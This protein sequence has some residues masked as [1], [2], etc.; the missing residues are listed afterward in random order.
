MSDFNYEQIKYLSESTLIFHEENDGQDF[1]NNEYNSI[2]SLIQN[3][4]S[5]N[6]KSNQN[7]SQKNTA[8]KSNNL[9]QEN[10][11]EN[12][13]NDEK[14]YN[15]I[16][17]INNNENENS[18]TVNNKSIVNT[19]NKI[20]IK[21]KNKK[22]K[23]PIFSINKKWKKR[24][25]ERKRNR[26]YEFYNIMKRIKK[27]LLESILRYVN[28]FIKG[29]KLLKIENIV[30]K[31]SDVE[32]NKAL[33]DT[34]LKDILSRDIYKK[35]KK[36]ELHHNK[37]IIEEIYE[38]RNQNII[39]ILNMKLKE[40][41]D[42]FK[43]NPTLKLFYDNLIYEMKKERSDNYVGTFDYYFDNYSEICQRRRNRKKKED[44]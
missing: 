25:R 34:S 6:I 8:E 32:I 9:S 17:K 19:N 5:N 29:K 3:T 41:V 31:E 38:E 36:Y 24:K 37:K 18:D 7:S 22:I 39:D 40:F 26:K 35:T 11:E 1:F 42:S 13:K 14:L 28:S 10:K 44:K 15:E 2:D 16:Q 4:S 33:L 30:S 12:I 23:G 21:K 27:F 20:K 43:D